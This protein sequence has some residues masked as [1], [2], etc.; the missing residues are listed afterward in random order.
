MVPGNSVPPSISRCVECQWEAPSI[1]LA[2][3]RARPWDAKD[4]SMVGCPSAGPLRAVSLGFSRWIQQ[5]FFAPQELQWFFF[6][7]VLCCAS[8]RIDVFPKTLFFGGVWSTHMVPLLFVVS[9]LQEIFLA[10]T[11]FSIGLFAPVFFKP[12]KPPGSCKSQDAPDVLKK[13]KFSSRKENVSKNVPRSRFS[14]LQLHA[15]AGWQPNGT[16]CVWVNP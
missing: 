13:S 16:F 11:F 2:A 6:E 14:N 10:L 8:F 15:D 3:A 5:K 9:V 7:I 4:T 1:Y 12:G